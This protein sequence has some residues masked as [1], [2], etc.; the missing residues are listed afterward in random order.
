MIP[1]VNSFV[2]PQKLPNAWLHVYPDSSH[3]FLF[4]NAEVFVKDVVTFLDN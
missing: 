3:G 4:Q 2:M 1:T